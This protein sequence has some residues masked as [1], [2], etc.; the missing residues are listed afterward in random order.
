MLSRINSAEL[1]RAGGAA[2]A[3]NDGGAANRANAGDRLAVMPCLAA[4]A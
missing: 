1:E 3:T 4:N 2:A